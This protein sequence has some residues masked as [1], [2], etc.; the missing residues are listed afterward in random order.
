MS[1][2]TTFS[3]LTCVLACALTT[4]ARASEYADA[5]GVALGT[6]APELRALDQAGRQRSLDDLARENGLLILFNRSADW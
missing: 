4:G 2:R 6:A 3:L 5:W 1:T